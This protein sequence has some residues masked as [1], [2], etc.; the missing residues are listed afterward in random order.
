LGDDE[1]DSDDSNNENRIHLWNALNQD[2][3]TLASKKRLILVSSETDKN[4]AT[5]IHVQCL[6]PPLSTDKM[7]LSQSTNPI[8]SHF[9]NLFGFE[10]DLGIGLVRLFLRELVVKDQA[11]MG[12]AKTEDGDGNET[13][14]VSR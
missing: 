7:R 3:E 2:A 13:G 8:S 5:S 10:S 14:R 6:S 11:R 4:I 9:G 1:W 12:N